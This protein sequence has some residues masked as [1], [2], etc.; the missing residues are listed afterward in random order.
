MPGAGLGSYPI[1]IAKLKCVIGHWD[2]MP[3]EN[4]NMTRSKYLKR[5][6][7]MSIFRH[8]NYENNAL[9]QCA[10]N[11][12]NYTIYTERVLLVFWWKIRGIFCIFQSPTIR[13]FSTHS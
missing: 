8:R 5:T 9:E 7:R 4:S 10:L 6:F 12:Y 3:V 2:I 1:A 13:R 11:N